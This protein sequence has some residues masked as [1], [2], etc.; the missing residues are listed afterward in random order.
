V[1][2][3]SSQMH[4]SR[5]SARGSVLTGSSGVRGA[6]AAALVGL[7]MMATWLNYSWP[8]DQRPITVYP[9]DVAYLLVAAEAMNEGQLLHK[10][11]LT[12]IGSLA[13]LPV[14]LGTRFF[15][16]AASA[17]GFLVASTA[18]SIFLLSLL[19]SWRRLSVVSAAVLTA[20][21]LA[22]VL[23]PIN[24]GEKYNALSIAM[25]YNKWCFAVLTI[26]FLVSFWPVSRARWRLDATILTLCLFVLFYTKITFF[27]VALTAAML[28]LAL[29]LR[30][31][32]P[33]RRI[34]VTLLVVVAIIALLPWHWRYFS[35]IYQSGLA[36][37]SLGLDLYRILDLLRANIGAVFAVVA[38]AVLLIAATSRPNR[39]GYPVIPV[40]ILILGGTFAALSQ[41]AQIRGIPSVIAFSIIL[42]EIARLDIDATFE[43][44]QRL[45]SVVAA[46]VAL[47]LYPAFLVL[48]SVLALSKYQSAASHFVSATG[49]S[50]MLSGIVIDPRREAISRRWTE[51][52]NAPEVRRAVFP[53]GDIFL[54]NPAAYFHSLNDAERLV[55]GRFDGTL[56]VWTADCVN[57]PALAEGFS[58]AP[59]WYLWTYATFAPLP[60]ETV[61]KDVD[62][63]M[64]PRFPAELDVQD[65]M[66]AAYGE[67][68]AAEFTQVASSEYWTL[69]VKPDVPAGA[70]NGLQG[71]GCPMP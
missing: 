33:K 16:T 62:A 61:F 43:K 15:G 30:D 49:G 60:A 71:K 58:P 39:S 65:A 31:P 21:G 25:H 12:P 28:S 26:A 4:P 3:S 17:L 19:A 64:I 24:L 37:D 2:D 66:L 68:V 11:Q 63:V 36:S 69:C 40:G 18:V 1:W 32:L 38:V 27:I 45:R 51:L 52:P 50:D 29:P 42:Y 9:Q 8:L 10:D 44:R 14:A 22:V 41:N 34:A 13:F 48:E 20:V 6:I 35:D 23:A 59:G 56:R 5:P 54:K 7:T 46:F 57:G 53:A 47:M 70:T 67:H 55:D